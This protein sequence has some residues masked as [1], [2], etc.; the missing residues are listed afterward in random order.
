MSDDEFLMQLSRGD[1]TLGGA[2]SRSSEDDPYEVIFDDKLDDQL[3]LQDNI[4]SEWVHL[5]TA[6]PL[7]VNYIGNLLVLASKRDFPLTRPPHF[8][9]QYIKDPNSFRATLAQVSGS[10]YSA[11]IGA[12]TAMD[13]IQLNVQQVPSHVKT[14][15]KLVL[16]GSPM[17]I[18]IMLPKALESIGRI[19]NESAADARTTFEKFTSLQELIAEII[20]ANT[21]THSG[22]TNVVQQIQSQIDKAK[23]D[24]TN[25]NNNINSIK[26][27]YEDSKR[28]MEKA[29]KE[30]QE[31]FNAI[32]T[33][34]RWFRKIF[35]RIIQAVVAVVT[36]PIRLLGCV[37]GLC[38]NNQA[39]L[40]A[41]LAAAE[42]A[43]QNAIAKANH[44]LQV[45][46]EAEKRHADF[47]AQQAMEQQKLVA[48]INK[49]AAL[50]LDRMSEQEIVDILI[51]SI[52]QMN[53]IKEQW[54][55]LIQFFSK[56]S[57]QADS[58]QQVIVHELISV[59]K[60]AQ[61]HNLLVDPSD[62]ELFVEILSITCQEIERGAHLLYVMSKTYHDVSSEYMIGQI[63]S[64][65]TLLLL[66]TDTERTA[67]LKSISSNTTLTST[68]ITQLA[69]A[70]QNEYSLRNKQR[71]DEYEQ[72]LAKIALEDLEVSIG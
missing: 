57:V 8:T 11:L 53:Q 6:G 61:E 27:Q 21:N 28:E 52:L 30:Y 19:A 29:R 5:M 62:R 58:T 17:L 63:T 44:L 51:E 16:A 69:Q 71:R 22:Q 43:K 31:A 41:A 47:A 33:A 45:L 3:A 1:D 20:E 23:E 25:L 4:D 37:L 70:R 35:R 54:G 56:L 72:F 13:R 64:M 65:N 36:A 67:Y 26:S 34:R 14:A 55:R 10:M 59:V 68:R 7:S 38:Y 42:T 39:A 46:K 24:Q 9:F 18:E 60:E 66:Q 15:L 32:P 49:I 48:I 40:N 2:L 12:H 50:D